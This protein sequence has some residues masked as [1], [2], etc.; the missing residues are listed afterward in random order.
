M[1]TLTKEQL[2]KILQEDTSPMN[3]PVQIFLD[4]TNNDE[5]IVGEISEQEIKY[6]KDF[7]C[8]FISGTYEEDY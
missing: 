7:K 4:C 1:K 3:T 6:D 8:L 5:S 2:I